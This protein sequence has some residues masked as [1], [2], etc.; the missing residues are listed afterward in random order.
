[1]G[2]CKSRPRGGRDGTVR[3]LMEL[4]SRLHAEEW[5]HQSQGGRDQI[6]K[7]FE[8]RAQSQGEPGI[9]FSH[10]SGVLTAEQSYTQKRFQQIHAFRRTKDS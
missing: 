9:S 5:Q 2:Q 6:M 10:K 3:H 1:M 7:G 8:G 4:E